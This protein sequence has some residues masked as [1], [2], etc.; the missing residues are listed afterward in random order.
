MFCEKNIIYYVLHILLHQAKIELGTSPI[1]K[2]NVP[3]NS[4]LLNLKMAE[5]CFV[6]NMCYIVKIV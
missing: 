3:T 2:K 1:T 5:F 4:L 6:F